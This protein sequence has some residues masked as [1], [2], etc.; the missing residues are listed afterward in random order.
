MTGPG[1]EG[2][3]RRAGVPAPGAHPGERVVDQVPARLLHPRLQIRQ[4]VSVGDGHK[5]VT[6]CSSGNN[7]G[8]DQFISMVERC[9]AAGVNVIADL[10]TNHMSGGFT[11][12]GSAGSGYDGNSQG[13]MIMREGS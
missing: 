11:G 13:C 2:V 5:L 1:T 3:L 10:V 4:Q 6:N 9:N 7:H 12:T 8:R